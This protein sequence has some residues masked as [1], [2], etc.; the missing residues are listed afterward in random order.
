[1]DVF[2]E[3]VKTVKHFVTLFHQYGNFRCP[4]ITPVTSGSSYVIASSLFKYCQKLL[5]YPFHG[6][7]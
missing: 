7:W 1:M 2:S 3:P 4:G 6:F 5:I